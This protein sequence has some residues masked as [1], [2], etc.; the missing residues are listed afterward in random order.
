MIAQAVLS[1]SSTWR[2]LIAD[3]DPATLH[4]VVEPSRNEPAFFAPQGVATAEEALRVLAS[5]AEVDLLLADLALPGMDGLQLLLAARKLRPDLKVVLMSGSP[6]VELER[7]ALE[8]GAIRL[9]AKPVDCEDLLALATDTPASLSHLEGDLDLLDICRLSVA[10]HA[11]RGVRVRH[12]GGEGVLV[13]RGSTL[14][15]A[16]AEG[17]TGEPAFTKMSGWSSWQFG[18]LSALSTA[19]LAVNCEL[20]LAAEAPRRHGVKAAGSMRGL[21]LRHL[22]EWAM[23]DRRSCIMTVSSNRR[24]GV[25]VFEAGKI[26]S[27]ETADHEGGAAAAE[28]LEWGNLRVEVV[29]AAAVERTADAP[30]PSPGE[31]LAALIDQFCGEVEGFIATCVVRRKD[32]SA[33]G[34]RSADPSLDPAAAAGSY[35]HVVE[36]HLAAVEHLGGAGAWGATE[37]I[38]ITTSKAYV[39]IRLLGD[40]H[41]HW[42]AVSN[43]ANLAMC[44]L[45]MRSFAA[46]LLSGLG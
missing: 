19:Y 1:P 9:V 18:S 32:G 5:D 7:A 6:S 29:H 44:R 28:I 26:R 15:H 20:D 12:D 40:G 34:G 23:Q 27:A 14:V 30:V 46:F 21:T 4:R 33:F 11:E 35:A 43:E 22:I 10:C 36:S 25:L 45:L 31:G 8:N 13:H 16:A 42:L 41:Y 3:A 38:L 39:L 37:D 17:A 2:L 24:H